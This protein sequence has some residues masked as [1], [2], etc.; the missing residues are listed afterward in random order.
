MRTRILGLWTALLLLG[1][2]SAL[3]S[4]QEQERVR[5]GDVSNAQQAGQPPGAGDV[6][7]E[8]EEA[9]LIGEDEGV[10]GAGQCPA[11]QTPQNQLTGTVAKATGTSLFLEE[12]NGAIVELKVDQNTRFTDPSVKGLKDVRVG[13]DVQASFE[14][15]GM[16]NLATSILPWTAVGGAGQEGVVE[17]PAFPDP[18]GIRKSDEGGIK[19]PEEPGTGGSGLL[20]LTP[21]ENPDVAGPPQDEDNAGQAG[22]I[23]TTEEP[24]TPRRSVKQRPAGAVDPEKAY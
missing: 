15:K 10:G 20:P 16:A 2:G 18:S 7:V 19:A 9:V 11:V 5:P 24:G 8:E 12:P 6:T 4:F 14:R 22:D 23:G 1:G 3:A 21:E 17:Q 13:Q